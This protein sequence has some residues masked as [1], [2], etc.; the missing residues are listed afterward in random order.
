MPGCGRALSGSTR[1]KMDATSVRVCHPAQYR[2]R[3]ARPC[4]VKA[5][6]AHGLARRG[7]GR[8]MR[9]P[10]GQQPTFAYPFGR[11]G[12][13]RKVLLTFTRAAR[14]EGKRVIDKR[15]KTAGCLP[16]A[17][18]AAAQAAFPPAMRGHFRNAF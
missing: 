16:L 10:L 6:D 14:P 11:L 17:R 9:A 5:A 13:N 1:K 3:N 4:G 15:E 8:A 7:I 12:G 18:S 2:A